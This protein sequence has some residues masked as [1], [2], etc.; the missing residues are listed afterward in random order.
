MDF[1][2]LLIDR[3]SPLANKVISES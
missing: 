1:P 2:K 3:V